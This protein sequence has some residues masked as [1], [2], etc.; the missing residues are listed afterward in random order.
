MYVCIRTHS[1]FTCIYIGMYACIHAD[2]RLCVCVCVCV[3]VCIYIRVKRGSH[4]YI[5]VYVC[6][7]EYMRTNVS[8]VHICTHTPTHTHKRAH[9]HTHACIHTHT[10]M[11]THTH[12]RTHTHARVNS[13]EKTV[14]RYKVQ[15]IPLGVTFSNAASKLKAQSS[16]VSFH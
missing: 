5:H 7:H 9:T 15:L 14:R 16:N 10:R 4:I 3:C 12:K 8:R 2:Q 1:R 6:M 11:H 13:K